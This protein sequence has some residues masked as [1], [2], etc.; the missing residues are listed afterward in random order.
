VR[1]FLAAV[2]RREGGTPSFGVIRNVSRTGLFL[3]AREN[4]AAGDR[5]VVDAIAGGETLSL[6]GIVVRVLRY[7]STAFPECVAGVQ[8][9]AAGSGAVKRVLEIADAISTLW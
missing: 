9:D 7:P 1:G 4:L 3:A 8:F 5:V 6:P 2:V